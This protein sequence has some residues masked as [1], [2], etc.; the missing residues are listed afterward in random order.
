MVQLE[1]GTTGAVRDIYFKFQFLYGT[2]GSS[3]TYL[4]P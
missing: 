2:I 4:N 1:D 3:V